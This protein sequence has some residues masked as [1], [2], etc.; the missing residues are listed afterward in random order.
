MRILSLSIALAA[1]SLL[2]GCLGSP[3]KD[4]TV[5]Y[6]MMPDAAGAAKVDVPK[7]DVDVLPITIPA[8]MSRS[9]IVHLH[10]G[11]VTLSEFDRWAE[12]PASGFMRAVISVLNEAAPNASLYAYPSVS[13]KK[14]N[15]VALR[16]TIYECIGQTGGDL[17][18]K[19]QVRMDKIGANA[20]PFV[21]EI[22][23]SVP[24]GKTHAEY[25]DAIN[26]CIKKMSDEIARGLAL[27]LI[28]I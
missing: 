24:C 12:S 17:N 23:Y 6:L 16:I 11:A 5:F 3:Q 18:F 13:G 2:G 22:N 20:E 25:V 8:Y 1:A 9:Q 10:G 15:S 26:V 19:G 4:P 14:E 21:K 7:C 28:H 27:S